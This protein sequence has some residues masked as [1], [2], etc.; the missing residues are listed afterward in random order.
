MRAGETDFGSVT[1]S[2]SDCD[3]RASA[4]AGCVSRL[5]TVVFNGSSAAVQLEVSFYFGFP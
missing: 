2:N 4:T 3:T 5:V 1:I